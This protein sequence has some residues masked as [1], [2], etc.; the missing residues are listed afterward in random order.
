VRL[1]EET[2]KTVS[3]PGWIHDRF[4]HPTSA[5]EFGMVYETMQLT[6]GEVQPKRMETIKRPAPRT[7]KTGRKGHQSPFSRD[8]RQG[9][10]LV[11]V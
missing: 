4:T 6:P 1:Q 3:P 11:G 8:G 10:S 5:A 2:E 9:R 7:H